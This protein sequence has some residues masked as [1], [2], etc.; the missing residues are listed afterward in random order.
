MIPLY[1]RCVLLGFDQEVIKLLRTS[2]RLLLVTFFSG[3]AASNCPLQ[4]LREF[5]YSVDTGEL[6]QELTKMDSLLLAREESKEG[7][8]GEEE[9]EGEFEQ[10]RKAIDFEMING[11][12]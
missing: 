9:E 7:G 3:V 1:Q 6:E 5:I 12:N 8:V 4:Q 10:L 11:S 2:H